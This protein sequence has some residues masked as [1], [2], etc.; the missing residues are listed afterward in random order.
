MYLQKLRGRAF[1]LFLTLGSVSAAEPQKSVELTERVITATRT[2]TERWRTASSVTV[3]DRKKIDEQQLKLLPDALRQVPG[4]VIADRGTPGSTVGIFLRGTNSDQTLVV[5]DGRPVPG[6]L[7]GLYNIETMALDNVE[8]IE[9]LSGPA[10]SLYGG[11]TLGGVINIITRSG[12]GLTKPESALSWE[13]GSFGFSRETLGTRGSAGIYDWSVELSRTDT[14]GYRI[15]SQMQLTN[16]AAKFGAQL[17]DTLRFDLDLRYYNADIGDPNNTDDPDNHL[18]TEFWSLS[19]RLV[20]DTTDRWNQTLTY[21][22][23][24]FRQ[25]ATGYPFAGQNNRITSRNHFWEY[26]SVFRVTDKWTLSGG[27]SVQDLAYNRYNDDDNPLFFGFPT[28]PGSKSYDVDQE[29]T[30]WALFLQSQ[31]EILPGWNL[32]GGL[33]YDSYSDF[34]EATTWRAGTSWR[35]PWTQTILHA[36]YGTAFAPASPQNREAGVWGFAGGEL[37]NHQPELSKGLELGIEQPFAD[38]KASIS[39]TYFHN[40]IRNLIVYDP[41]LFALSQV[42][43]AR[44]QGLESAFNWQPSESFGFSAQYTYLDAQD[45]SAGKRLVRRPR[46]TVTSDIWVKPMPK[47]RLGLGALYIIDREEANQVDVEDYLRLRLTASYEL[48]KNCDLF[49]RVENLLGERYSEVQGFPAMRTGAY[50]GF[51]LRF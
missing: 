18:L 9:V 34:G 46:H 27:M 11:K 41:L 39:L 43:Q 29:E 2:E 10:S 15:N 4:L 14:Q 37:V 22:F 44:T 42:N 25:V 31:A 24:N 3:I 23:G 49:A 1:V 35:M 32:T 5:I 36:N 28:N 17:A 12:K 51:R 13:G 8:R 45:T 33:R 40:N 30:N 6:N 50:A 47:L 26:Q 21:Q 19:P 7:A 16:T 48:S 20:W 38:N